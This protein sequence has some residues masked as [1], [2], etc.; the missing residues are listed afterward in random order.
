[1]ATPRSAD[2]HRLSAEQWFSSRGLPYFVDSVRADVRNR[3]DR[4]RLIALGSVSALFAAAAFVGIWLLSEDPSN[5][6]LAAMVASGIPLTAYATRGLYAG[7]VARWT[8]R[9][10]F[11]SLGLLV[12][13]VTRALPLL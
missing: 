1:M 6:I 2:E 10:T 13:L 3:L 9:R 5:S 7:T 4:P 11:S 8:I 12:P